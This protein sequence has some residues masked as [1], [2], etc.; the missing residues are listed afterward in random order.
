MQPPDMQPLTF[1]E[2]LSSPPLKT[3]PLTLP[4]NRVVTLHELPVA[5]IEQVQQVGEQDNEAPD[6]TLMVKI[7]RIAA[8]ALAGREP[9]DDELLKMGETFGTSA[10]MFIYYEALKFSRLGPDSFDATKKS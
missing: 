4:D 9:S 3:R 7:T 1:E 2:L 6:D 5:V 10:V 8:R